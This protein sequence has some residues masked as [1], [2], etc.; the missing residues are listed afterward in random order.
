[1]FRIGEF[2]RIARVSCRLLR[3]Y[4][5][6]GLL[7]PAEVDSASGYR[8]YSVRQLE[9]LNRILV[10]R[11]L[12]LGLE[13]I[14][15]AMDAGAD[16]ATLRS[17]LSVRRSEVEASIE[18][19]SRRLRQI[20]SRLAQLEPGVAADVD[21]VVMR[22][23]PGHRLLSLRMRVESFAQGMGVI[24]QLLREVLTRVESGAL[25]QF[26]AIAHSAEF[27]PEDIDVEFGFLLLGE[28]GTRLVLSDGRAMEVRD[29]AAVTRLATCVRVG[30][31][32]EAHA[33]TARIGRF[34]ESGGLRLAGPHRELFLARPHP[35]RMHEAVV[36]M[37]F[38]VA[39]IQD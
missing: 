30:P 38:P 35:Q 1:M 17:M 7:P 31:P 18:E 12:G 20:E 33:T 13:Q 39:P 5:E 8:Y 37:Q 22:S 6:I 21:D 25:G 36:E 10:L 32:Q 14:R 4:D 19:E 15:R 11:D 9:R 3:H 24:T 27:E 23:D 29:L 2:S 34:V 26:I 28:V 16:V